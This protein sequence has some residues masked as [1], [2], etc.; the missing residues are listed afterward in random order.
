MVYREIKFRELHLRN[1]E[2]FNFTVNYFF[3]HKIHGNFNTI[4]K[5]RFNEK[6]MRVRSVL[7]T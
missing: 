5:R 2:H 4:N 1:L 6:G 7:I 3:I